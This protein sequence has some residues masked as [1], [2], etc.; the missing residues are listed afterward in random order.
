M[1]YRLYGMFLS[2]FIILYNKYDVNVSI[3]EINEFY[4]FWEMKE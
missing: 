1:S 2:K 3:N 4:F